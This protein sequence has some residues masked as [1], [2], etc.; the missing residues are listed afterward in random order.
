MV[1]LKRGLNLSAPRIG[2]TNTIFIFLSIRAMYE[3]KL[4]VSNKINIKLKIICDRF[5]H[6]IHYRF[7][8]DDSLDIIAVPLNLYKS[9]VLRKCSI[10]AQKIQISQKIWKISNFM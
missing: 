5:A 9:Q 8:K 10:K 3:Y 1:T 4:H 6:K 2:I 7:L